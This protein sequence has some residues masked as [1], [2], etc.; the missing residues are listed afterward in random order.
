MER[1]A[2]RSSTSVWFY[3]Q[4]KEDNYQRSQKISPRRPSTTHLTVSSR[5]FVTAPQRITLL[6]Q[7]IG[8]LH[9]KIDLVA[10]DPEN[11]PNHYNPQQ[12]SW[13]TIATGGLPRHMRL[14]RQGPA[15]AA[16][17][18]SIALKSPP[19]LY[20]RELVAHC[21]KGAEALERSIPRLVEDLKRATKQSRAVGELQS[22]RKL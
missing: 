16:V 22:M 6:H 21:I 10:Q 2:S 18:A 11:T 8:A 13:S 7:E 14:Q 5:S 3:R 9:N 17:T 19:Q 4:H 15:L 20:H 12:P 1:A